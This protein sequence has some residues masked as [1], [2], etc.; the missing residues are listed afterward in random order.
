MKPKL[1]ITIFLGILLVGVAGAQNVSYCCERLVSGGWCYDASQENC[2]ENYR[3][4][5]TSCE[6]TSYCRMG[7][8][9]DSSEGTC[10][11]NTA[12]KVCEDKGG[13]WK[14]EDVDELP[15]C[16]LGCCLM[17]D[18]AAFVTQSRC[19]VISKLYGLETVFRTDISSEFEC[20]ASATS[21]VLG[22]CVFEED[23]QTTCLMLTQDECTEGYENYTFHSG[24]LCSAED[25]AT[26]CGPSRKTTCVE[27]KDEVYF[28]D[29][30]EN[31][32][33]VYD[34]S[35]INNNEY[36]TNIYSEEESCN[37]DSSNANSAECGNCDYYLGSTCKKYSVSQ[38]GQSP[39]Y[40]DYICRDLSCEYDGE[41]Y[42]HGETW[43]A[44]SDGADDNL[45][46]SRYFRLIC[47]NGE[48]TIE[49]CD[50]FRGEV[51]LQSDID[52]FKTA[53]C[54]TNRW[55]ACVSQT[56]KKDCENEDRRDCKWI[57]TGWK[58]QEGD[59]PGIIQSDG[60]ACVPKYT[61]GFNFWE[62]ESAE[63]V[64]SAASVKCNVV[65]EDPLIG[66]RE[67]VKNCKCL[68]KAWKEDMNEIFTS[69]GD[70]GNKTNFIGV[71]GYHDSEAWY[72]GEGEA[73]EGGE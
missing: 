73:E 27:G 9:I 56:E 51:C 7:T 6:A 57:E 3:S 11:G 10:M 50:D 72:S 30:C 33:N 54:R 16:E 68:T 14:E 35:K 60:N 61:P 25:L 4:T 41:T 36:W 34:A 19:K 23:Y 29:T 47:Y 45:P 1:L 53:A 67:C 59:T 70:C 17:G 42:G 39:D 20:I 62:S 44:N 66:D 22:A 55:Q 28:L 2:D 43:C 69:I 63:E 71:S 21:D 38:D 65:F 46:G 40:G 8:C 12:Q 5:P 32:A 15:Q 64:C 18:Q 58:P 31:I 26:N 24:Y 48:V 37:Y 52:G 13:V 49:A